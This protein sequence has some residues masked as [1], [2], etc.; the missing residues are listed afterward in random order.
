M[1]SGSL[2]ER[3]RP[4]ADEHLA[5]VLRW[6]GVIDGIARFSV[7]FSDGSVESLAVQA[8]GF[9]Q[10]AWLLTVGES[11]LHDLRPDAARVAL[12]VEVGSDAVRLEAGVQRLTVHLREPG[13]RWRSG[14]RLLL[15]SPGPDLNVG[16]AARSAA[17]QRARGERAISFGLGHQEIIYGGGEDFGAM[18]KNGRR[19][20]MRNEDA[21]GVNGSAHYHCVPYLWSTRGYGLA[22]LSA[23]PSEVDLATRH[24]VLTWRVGGPGLSLLV[25]PAP[26]PRAAVAEFRQRI[27]AARDVPDWSARLWLSRCYYRDQAEVDQVL[28]EARGHG[29][30]RGVVNLD[31]RCWMRADT[32]T[33]FVWDRSRFEP[34]ANYIPRVRNQGFAV[35]LWENP[36]VSSAADLWQQGVRR[37]FFATER[38]GGAYPLRWVPEGLVGFPATPPAGLVDFTSE[39]AREWWKDLH[40]PYLRAGVRCFKTDFGEEVPP[41]ARFADGSTGAELRNVYADLYNRCVTEV[42]EE[43]CGSDA[44]VWARSGWFGAAR[45]PV[46]WAGD[47]QT[48]WR[49][50]R[51]TLRAGLGQAVAG[52]LFWSHDV[53]GFYGPPPDP[54]LFVRWAQLAMYG[55]HVRCH[56]TTAREPWAFGEPALT[57]FMA[58]YRAREA[59]LEDICAGYRWCVRERLSFVRPLWMEWPDDLACATIDDQFMSGPDRLVVPFVDAE[60]GRSYYLPAGT[61]CDERDGSVHRGPRYGHASRTRQLPAFRRIE[62]G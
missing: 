3:A 57:D 12:Q 6:R 53:G 34:F 7:E 30:A 59:R 18:I 29:I 48:S 50:L 62:P 2:A 16:G 45:T 40:R 51:A 22:V 17:V 13:F 37:G 60:G 46:K 20:A 42:L 31:A 21:L 28:A 49:A 4:R 1:V 47:S 39:S 11:S 25:Q 19:I 35:S 23:A 15:A 33:D 10:P 44:I 55:S 38:G 14:D 58:A 54:E 56:G 27:D 26:S 32:R 8:L 52:A 61:W 41:D 5:R 36:Y 24:E 43:E 9:S